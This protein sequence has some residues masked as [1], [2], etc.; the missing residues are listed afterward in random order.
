MFIENDG[1]FEMFM[2]AHTASP[3]AVVTENAETGYTDKAVDASVK[4]LAAGKQVEVPAVSVP[5]HETPKIPPLQ[6]VVLP[7]NEAE[8]VWFPVAG[9]TS[10][11][12]YKIT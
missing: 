8:I 4:I 12:Q 6:S 7:E 10:P 2:P 1:T 5:D 9:L 3:L 11:K